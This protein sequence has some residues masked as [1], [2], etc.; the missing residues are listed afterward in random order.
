MLKECSRQSVR[1]NKM[2]M[3]V[4]KNF[5]FCTFFHQLIV[6]LS[7]YRFLNLFPR[8]INLLHGATINLL[9]NHSTPRPKIGT[10][11]RKL[12][13]LNFRRTYILQTEFTILNGKIPAQ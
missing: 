3:M 13:L 12:I 6:R 10:D 5:S 2:Q 1:R 8:L 11:V 4:L 9:K 7:T